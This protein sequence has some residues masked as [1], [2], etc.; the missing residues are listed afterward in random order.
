MPKAHSQKKRPKKNAYRFSPS[1]R[2]KEIRGRCFVHDGDTIRIRSTWIRISYIDAPELSTDY[3]KKS[4]WTLLNICKGKTIIARL[5]GHL[6]YGR[7]VAQC[8]LEDGTN[9]AD[10]MTSK[11]MAW[12]SLG[13]KPK[14][15]GK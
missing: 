6:S 2:G 7:H 5:S 1:H 15:P 9:L 3:G 12:W 10:A 8:Y 11:R 13:N 14:R 4:K